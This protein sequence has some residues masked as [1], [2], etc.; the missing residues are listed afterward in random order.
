MA[1]PSDDTAGNRSLSHRRGW[2]SC[3]PAGTAETAGCSHGHVEPR[4][5]RNGRRFVIEAGDQEVLESNLL[6]DG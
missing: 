4:V 2:A 5:R 3:S 1:T 6:F